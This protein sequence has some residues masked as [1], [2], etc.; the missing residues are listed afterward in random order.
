[1]YKENTTID[2]TLIDSYAWDTVTQWIANTDANG[3]EAGKTVT[4]SYLIRKLYQ[5]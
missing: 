2:S 4:D 5:Q 3:E 1:M